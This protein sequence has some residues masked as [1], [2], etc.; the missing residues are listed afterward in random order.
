MDYN[1]NSQ[2]NTTTKNITI[3]TEYSLLIFHKLQYEKT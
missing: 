2:H 3:L 1:C